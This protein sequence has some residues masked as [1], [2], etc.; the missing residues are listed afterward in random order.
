MFLLSRRGYDITGETSVN[1]FAARN[2]ATVNHPTRYAR[3]FRAFSGSSLVP[4]SSMESPPNSGK[5]EGEIASTLLRA[6]P[7]ND[8]LSLFQVASTSNFNDTNRNPF[9]RYQSLSRLANLVTTR[10]NVYA[11]WITVG[12]FEAEWVGVGPA[13]PDGYRLG[14]ELGSDTGDIKRHRAFYLIDRSIPA[15]FVRGQDL[16]VGNTILLNRFIE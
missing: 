4:L 9:F 15:G 5:R 3:P 6:H 10:S 13:Y 7:D 16:N 14:R 8:A 11:V 1:P 2:D 12:Y